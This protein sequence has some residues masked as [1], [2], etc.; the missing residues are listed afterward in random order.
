MTLPRATDARWRPTDDKPTVTL[1][2]PSDPDLVNSFLNIR[3]ADIQAVYGFDAT[4]TARIARRAAVAKGHLRPLSSGGH[5]GST[6]Q[7]WRRFGC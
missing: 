4:P 2:A 3:V 7:C 5:R 6:L 1:E